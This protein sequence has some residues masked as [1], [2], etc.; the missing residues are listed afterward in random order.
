MWHEFT[1]HTFK[2]KKQLDASSQTKLGRVSWTSGSRRWSWIPPLTL[3][4][5]LSLSLSLSFSLAR[6]L[7]LQCWLDKSQRFQI[8]QNFKVKRSRQRSERNRTVSTMPEHHSSGTLS[9]FCLSLST[10]F[11]LEERRRSTEWLG[12]GTAGCHT[13][14]TRKAIPHTILFWTPIR[15]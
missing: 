12:P 2:E 15:S 8:I 6:S 3:S 14:P 4:R 9:L 13:G 5:S 7:S 10:V 11:I 1:L